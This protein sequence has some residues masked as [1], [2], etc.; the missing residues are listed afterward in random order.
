MG[1]VKLSTAGILNYQK[2]DDFLAGNPAYVPPGAY[3]LIE[4]ITPG[5]QASVTFSG[6][7]DYS[8]TYKHLQLRYVMRTD[9]GGVPYSNGAIRINGDTGSNYNAHYLTGTGSSVI[10]GFVSSATSMLITSQPGGTFTTNAFAAGVVDF[11][12]AY[13]SNKN[14]TVRSLSGHVGNDV[15]IAL[16]SGLWRNTA[17]ITSITVLNWDGANIVSGSRFSLYGLRSS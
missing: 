4:T 15:N 10:S 13:N 7:G 5:T 1:V 12:D 2:Y 3:E 6:L 14:T 11:L 16:Q 8:S 9:R 17:S